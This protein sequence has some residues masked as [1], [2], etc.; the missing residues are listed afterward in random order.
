MKSVFIGRG[1]LPVAAFVLGM[2]ALPAFAGGYSIV[3]LGG[4]G[5]GTSSANG[6]NNLGQVVGQ[7]NPAVWSYPPSFFKARSFGY[8]DGVATEIAVPGSFWSYASAISENGKIVGSAS[9]NGS[10]MTQAYLYSNGTVQ[11]LG[12][13]GGGISA[14][15][16]VNNSGQVVGQSVDS[17]QHYYAFVYSNGAMSSLGALGGINSA[18]TAINNSGQISGSANLA[19]DQKSH[20]FLYANGAM[21]D[22]GT[23]GGLRSGGYDL[24][25]LGQV[26]GESELAA[27][28]G[29]YLSHAF[30]FSAGSMIDLGTLGGLSSYATAINLKSQI[31]GTAQNDSGEY[32]PFLYRDGA[33]TDL[34]HL[35]DIGSGWV[36]KD[37]QDIN[38]RG[39]I[40]GY[41]IF[42][43]EERAFLMT[44]SSVPVP[45][46]AWLLGS[47][48]L[49][50][51]G[52]A[53]RRALT[54]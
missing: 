43:G 53:R 8:T 1:V 17:Q 52:A 37:V 42:N 30:L 3:D 7:F 39:Q 31:V 9:T 21:Q 15:W 36:L 6:I 40:V 20:A 19:G 5:G 50:L 38:D 18:A 41:G 54:G 45:G 4:I 25:D 46:A 34:A 33:M 22:L 12:H 2:T 27:V 13:L 51:L 44:P 47:G 23:L 14:A 35:L 32:R 11:S 28:D 29:K 49:G 10:S 26:V 48:L 24:N 16:G